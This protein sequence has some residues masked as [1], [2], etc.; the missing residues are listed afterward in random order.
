MI[1]QNE[2]KDGQQAPKQLRPSRKAHPKKYKNKKPEKMP[3]MRRISKYKTIKI[4]FPL[5][6]EHDFDTPHPQDPGHAKA[7]INLVNRSQK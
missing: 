7:F 2:Q 6:R 1:Y 5:T 4:V 3:N